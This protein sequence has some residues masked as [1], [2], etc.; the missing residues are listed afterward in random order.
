MFQVELKNGKGKVQRVFNI[1]FAMPKEEVK[2]VQ[3]IH[4]MCF[5]TEAKNSPFQRELQLKE[6][7]VG[8]TKMSRKEPIY[9]KN[10]GRKL[11]FGRALKQFFTKN[12]RLPFWQ[13]F[14]ER[15]TLFSSNSPRRRYQK[16]TMF[17]RDQLDV[18]QARKNAEE[19][20]EINAGE[21]TK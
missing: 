12:E 13:E 19:L 8:S 3:V 2:G 10:R 16:N 15:F 14:E 21:N 6:P 1:K 17:I 7:V 9:D 20:E 11:A 18:K 4:T 5:I